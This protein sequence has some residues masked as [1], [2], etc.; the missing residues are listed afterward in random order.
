MR[1]LNSIKLEADPVR[2]TAM[3]MQRC[4]QHAATGAA[5]GVLA[6]RVHG[7][8]PRHGS[9]ILGEWTLCRS[10]AVQIRC[11]AV[12]PRDP[13]L[14]LGCASGILRF[15]VLTAPGGAP[16][17]DMRQSQAVRLLSYRGRCR[18]TISCTTPQ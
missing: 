15:A 18:V 5:I 3:R 11:V 4:R 14:L 1:E 7:C 17:A 2:M 16:A 12:M 13:F 9:M 10:P 8:C 6:L